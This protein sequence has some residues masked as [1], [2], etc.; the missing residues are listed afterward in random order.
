M[1]KTYKRYIV[2][3]YNQYYPMGGLTDMIAT[4][5]TE[6]ELKEFLLAVPEDKHSDDYE[7][8]DCL[9][10]EEITDRFI[11]KEVPRKP[12]DMSHLTEEERKKITLVSDLWAKEVEKAFNN[13]LVASKLFNKTNEKT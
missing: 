10:G 2:F 3:G 4:F 6:S 5:D 13:P 11:I 7:V 1:T 8:L 12:V 9:E